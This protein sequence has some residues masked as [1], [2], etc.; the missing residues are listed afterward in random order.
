MINVV[1]VTFNGIKW[2][3]KC[4]TSVLNSSI[5]VS[6]I[7]VDNCGTDDTVKF[8]K[9]NFSEIILLEQNENFGFGKANNIGIKMAYES[10]ANYVFLLNQDAWVETD[11]IEKLVLAH[12][13][14][15]E[16]G[17]ISPIHLNGKGDA[18][19]YNFSNYIIPSN[20]K[21][22]YSDIFLKSIEDKIYKISF[23]NA[24]AWLVSRE[25]IEK[26]GGFNPSFYHYGEDDNYIQRLKF[27]AFKVGVLATSTICH[28]RE[29]PNEN[30]HF[31]NEKL[32]Y[33]RK[34]ILEISNPLCNYTFKTE[35][36][37]VYKAAIKSILFLRKN[38]FLKNIAKIKILNSLNKA[39]ILKNREESKI[40]KPSFLT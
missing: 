30:F 14:E 35:Y 33:K 32:L 21:Y 2:I 11:T 37:K 7:V 40:A 13:K 5:P 16:Y 23:V 31:K 26:I 29:T 3:D 22:I 24:A 9:A 18:L 15:P 38:A 20:C 27:H 1:I 19:D 8:I 36:K 6:V 17:V 10:G 4:L 12:Q 25:C 39:I 28:D 34:I